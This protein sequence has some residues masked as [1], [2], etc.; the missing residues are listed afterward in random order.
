M[1]NR[2][3]QLSPAEVV[4]KVLV[5]L[6]IVALSIWMVQVM[7]RR[8]THPNQSPARTWIDDIE[9]AK[10]EFAQ[11]CGT[12]AKLLV[13]IVHSPEKK[14]W[15][16]HGAAAYM[17]MCKNTQIRLIP[18]ADREASEA[19]VRG[20]VR[21]TAWTPSDELFLADLADLEAHW[22]LRSG[23]DLAPPEL[24]ASL[25]H[26]PMVL[27]VWADRLPAL[28]QLW[29]DF[30]ADRRWLARLACA[31]VPR[32]S[33]PAELGR[34]LNWTELWPR[35]IVGPR[36]S[37][38]SPSPTQ[39]RAW[40]QVEFVHPIPPRSSLGFL[41]L[42]TMVDGYLRETGELEYVDADEFE[43]AL[44]RH[45]LELTAWLRHCQGADGAFSGSPRVLTQRM[46]QRG[47]FGVDGVLT[48]EHLALEA[49][50]QHNAGEPGT[51]EIRILYP[52]S[53]F[54]S[55]HPIVFFAPDEGPGAAARHF[56]EFLHTPEVQRKAVALGFRP[57]Q[58]DTD[59]RSI[60][61][62]DNPFLELRR[63]GVPL[64]LQPNEPPRPHSYGLHTLVELWSDATDRH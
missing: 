64:V 41:A 3:D 36:N 61:L 1:A 11:R 32:A 22:H 63:F 14:A 21:P 37:P 29:P 12:E 40:Q 25:I 31:G 19:I 20:T 51:A 17:R 44:E 13:T 4:R 16:L 2:R 52:E 7:A 28:E 35:L 59:L 54:V 43:A 6:G 18:A 24:G 5:L 8:L 57:A 53:G 15:L 58:L 60:D 55:N 23:S 56:A 26:T 27:L 49:V 46:L 30:A 50:A 48:Y 62:V 34:P 38:S 33:E 10:P 42:L 39:L 9:Y 45:E 47:E